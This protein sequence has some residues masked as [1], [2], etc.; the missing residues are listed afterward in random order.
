M[1]VPKDL[2]E[3]PLVQARRP[4]E[5][6]SQALQPAPGPLA[7]CKVL[8][9]EVNGQGTLLRSNL[10][11]GYIEN[12][13]RNG[14]NAKDIVQ[15]D[16]PAQQHQRLAKIH[17]IACVAINARCDQV[18]GRLGFERID[19]SACTVKDQLWVKVQRQ[20]GAC[21]K[22]GYQRGERKVNCKV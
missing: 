7:E 1:L 13:G 15:V 22:Y 11:A 14:D 4:S 5:L 3:Y 21:D 20:P 10:E 12:E 16:C 9:R 18:G 2:P 19:R 17:R 8:S 6:S